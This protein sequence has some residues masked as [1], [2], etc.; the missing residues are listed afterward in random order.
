[1]KHC[2]KTLITVFMV[3]MLTL[4]GVPVM[5]KDY[6]VSK[7]KNSEI[8][9]SL[10]SKITA[11]LYPDKDRSGLGYYIGSTYDSYGM[12]GK[13]AVKVTAKSDNSRVATVK[14]KKLD[15]NWY[16]YATLKKPGTTNVTV[17]VNGKSY[18]TK[19]IV[20]KYVNPVSSI[21]VGKT[22]I[23]GSRFNKKTVYNLKY[24]KFANKKSTITVRLKKGWKL[25]WDVE[26]VKKGWQKNSN[27]KNGA[28]LKIDGGKGFFISFTAQNTKTGQEEYVVVFF[29]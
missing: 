23:K 5:A 8:H 17:K 29:K 3:M 14:A 27:I 22:I 16:I 11:T 28:A 4:I 9:L 21:K 19:L 13:T 1:M 25:K 6:V 20:K 24:S 7:A 2:R 18:K 15:G 26:Y 12:N 10:E